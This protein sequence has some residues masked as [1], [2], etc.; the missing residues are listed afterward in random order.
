MCDS[1]SWRWLDPSCTLVSEV[2]SVVWDPGCTSRYDDSWAKWCREN[3]VYTHVD[4]GHVRL[5]GAS[6]GDED[7]PEIHYGPSDVWAF[8]CSHQWLDWRNI[9]HTLEENTQNKEGLLYIKLVANV[10][11]GRYYFL[12]SFVWEINIQYFLESHYMKCFKKL[13]FVVSAYTICITFGQWILQ[14]YNK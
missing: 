7:E 8:G 10:S 2:N 12:R 9:L 4:E 3:Q 6:Q 1:G 13:S 11:I 5:R 14:I